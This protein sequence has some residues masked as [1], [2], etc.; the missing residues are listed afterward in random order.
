M[1]FGVHGGHEKSHLSVGRDC[2]TWAVDEA[3]DKAVESG[4]STH[5]ARVFKRLIRF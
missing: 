3:V 1:I 2:S 5:P 4:V